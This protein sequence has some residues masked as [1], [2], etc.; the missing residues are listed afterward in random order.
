M[1]TIGY[2]L[3]LFGALISLSASSPVTKHPEVIQPVGPAPGKQASLPDHGYLVVYS[4]WD[5]FAGYDESRQ[6]RHSGYN[7]YSETG[8]KIKR[9]ANYS[10]NAP[11][12]PDRVE[13]P[14][15]SYKAVVQSKRGRTVTV[16]VIIREGQTTF[17]FLDG[18]TKS[19]TLLEHQ[20]D[21]VKLPDGEIIG[22]SANM[23]QK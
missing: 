12:V 23:A 4:G 14:A 9:V 6:E 15:G 21:A 19:G 20:A 5:I 3:I 17:V 1:K 13:L 22:W 10:P 2:Y 16:P 18:V 8:K 11:E 7:L